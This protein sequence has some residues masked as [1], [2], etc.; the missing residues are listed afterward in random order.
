MVTARA[1]LIEVKRRLGDVNTP[2]PDELDALAYL[3]RAL[4]GIYNYGV[5]LNSPMLKQ[6]LEASSDDDGI[7]TVSDGIVRVYLVVLRDSARVLLP[8][9]GMADIMG[10]L[11]PEADPRWYKA[12]A[13]KIQI[14]PSPGKSR[15][16]AMEY[17]P[18]LAPIADRDDELPVSRTLENVLVDWTVAL[19]KDK[20]MTVSD[21]EFAAFLGVANTLSNYYR[22]R[23]V[24]RRIVGRGPW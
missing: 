19:I 17:I 22:G 18:E 13:D 8:Y 9:E 4:L 11:S 12:Y 10:N 5:H 20:Q 7:V 23:E 16:I 21:I 6:V 3:N 14:I 1:V 2:Y 24:G 15:D